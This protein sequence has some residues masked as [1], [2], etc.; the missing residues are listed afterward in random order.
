MNNTDNKN[1]FYYLPSLNFAYKIP[2]NL[3]EKYKLEQNIYVLAG[4]NMRMPTSYGFILPPT[5][6]DC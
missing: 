2:C 6:D 5:G 3:G 4:K 1:I